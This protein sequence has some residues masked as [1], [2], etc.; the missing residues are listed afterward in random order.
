VRYYLPIFFFSLLLQAVQAQ[1]R[2]D[3]LWEK[4]D[5]KDTTGQIKSYLL[6]LD[7]YCHNEIPDTAALLSIRLIDAAQKAQSKKYEYSGYA[8]LADVY[9]NNG[10]YFK[11]ISTFEKG[12]SVQRELGGKEIASIFNDIGRAYR[13]LGDQA[14]AIEYFFKSVKLAHEQ[15]D[16][17]LEATVYNNMALV[18]STDGNDSIALEY[19]YK[20]LELHK[21]IGDSAG[22]ALCYS[23]IGELYRS[24]KRLKEAG[25]NFE[26]ALNI[27]EAIQD[28]KQ[29]GFAFSN[30]GAV[31]LDDKGYKKALDFFTKAKSMYEAIHVVVYVAESKIGISEAHFGLG[32]YALAIKFAEEALATGEQI[33]SPE[34]IAG[35]ANQLYIVYN[36]KSD[37]KKSLHYLEMATKTSNQLRKKEN[38]N[39][40]E[41]YNAKY[42][43]E[44]KQLEVAALEKDLKLE[45][46][47][48]QR[49]RI[50]NY[51]LIIGTVSL[52][53]VAFILWRAIKQKQTANTLLQKSQHTIE[54]QNTELKQLS[55]VKDKLLSI[56]AHDFRGPLASING[57]IPLLKGNYLSEAERASVLELLTSQLNATTYF[58]ENLLQ[59][60]RSQFTNLAPK[61]ERIE[62]LSVITECIQLLEGAA[63]AKKIGIQ[64]N[65]V[66]QTVLADIEMVRFIFRNLISN[67]LKFSHEG[68]SVVIES[69][70]AAG[71]V[72][73]SV[74][75]SGVGI[76]T[77]QLNQ[78]FKLETVITS[79]TRNERGTGLGLTLCKDFVLANGGTI[80][81]ES[82]EGLGT[83]FSFSLPLFSQ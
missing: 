75:D 15:K 39:A 48:E 60:S 18:F 76:P 26:L 53:I 55:T 34:L 29:L 17:Q 50:I 77:S 52:L 72:H 21:E 31:A 79:G 7:H 16:I 32:N 64:N 9:Y 24:Q 25:K 43:L 54:L 40:L 66:N 62:I 70:L 51:V 19:H 73:F 71:S 1:T 44:K 23:N 82:K 65:A 81:V 61:P 22:M 41:N 27:S 33:Q 8:V 63:T 14:K 46:A 10:D 20:S 80:W 11:A 68:T 59:W 47:Q 38:K 57:L 83:T 12:L 56:T 74:K 2:I 49:E 36:Q 35:S 78:L 45:Q 4:I 58:L 37:F 30:I 5:N 42:I 13:R 6:L 67:A 69:K 3:S 28:K